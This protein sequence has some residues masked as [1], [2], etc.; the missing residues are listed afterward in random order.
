MPHWLNQHDPN[1]ETPS[2]EVFLSD[3]QFAKLVEL[4][5]PG[6]LLAQHYLAEA[7]K[8]PPAPPPPALHEPFQE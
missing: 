1:P 7:G 6:Y 8:Q 5:T 3:A 2:K 4:L